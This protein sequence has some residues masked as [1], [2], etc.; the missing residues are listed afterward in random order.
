MPQKRL[1]VLSVSKAETL[2]GVL[3]GHPI[4]KRISWSVVWCP[5]FAISFELPDSTLEMCLMSWTPQSWLALDFFSN[6][7]ESTRG[8]IARQDRAGCLPPR[9]T[10][11]ARLHHKTPGFEQ[12]G[13]ILVFQDLARTYSGGSRETLPNGHVHRYQANIVMDLKAIHS[14]NTYWALTMIRC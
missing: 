10:G 4:L 3:T 2:R 13:T 6:S 11:L 8:W 9:Q 12:R 1:Q 14:A 7:Q 5:F